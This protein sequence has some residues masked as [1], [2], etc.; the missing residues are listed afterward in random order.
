MALVPFVPPTSA[1]NTFRPVSYLPIYTEYGLRK[2]MPFLRKKCPLLC[3]FD[4]NW[5]ILPNFSIIPKSQIS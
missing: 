4:Q 1:R 5:N 2:A 3:D